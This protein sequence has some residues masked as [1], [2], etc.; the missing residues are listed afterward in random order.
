M[1]KNP[2]NTPDALIQ[3]TTHIILRKKEKY[4]KIVWKIM[5]YCDR[6]GRDLGMNNYY[7]Y[8]IL[9]QKKKIRQDL[10]L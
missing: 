7:I 5:E 9:P 3:H 8:G 2:S 1:V 4:Y 6:I 10:G